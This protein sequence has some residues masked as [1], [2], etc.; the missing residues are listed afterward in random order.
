MRVQPDQP[1]ASVV[2]P[3]QLPAQ[4]LAVAT[5]TAVADDRDYGTTT[6]HTPAPF[7]VE[8]AQTLA[9][10]SAARPIAYFARRLIDRTVRGERLGGRP[11]VTRT[12]AGSAAAGRCQVLVVGPSEAREAADHLARVA[13]RPILTVGD[14]PRFVARG[15][16]IEFVI[17]GS[18]VRFL[19]DPARADAAGLTLSSDLLR[20]ARLFKPPAAPGS[21]QQP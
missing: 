14:V 3:A 18:R 19:V 4:Q 17:E 5:V 15:G 20:V 16:M 11:V 2:Q 21:P 6:Q 9:D 7:A 13:G 12:L 10:S 8:S 1:V